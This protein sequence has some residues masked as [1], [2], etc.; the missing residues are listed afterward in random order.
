MEAARLITLERNFLD[1]RA[2]NFAAPF[3][4]KD[5]SPL[6]PLND[7]QAM[8]IGTIRDEIDARQILVGNY[9]YNAVRSAISTPVSRNNNNHYQE[10][11]NAGLDFQTDLQYNSRLWNT[12]K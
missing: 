9:R 2:R 7:L 5:F 3:S 10:F 6:E 11:D 1:V 8:I 4:S 12:K